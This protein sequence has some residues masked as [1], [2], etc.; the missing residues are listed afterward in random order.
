MLQ[1][2]ASL[3]AE[4][5]QVLQQF[6]ALDFDT[7]NRMIE[8][9]VSTH[10]LPLGIATNFIVNQKEIL[11]PMA[12]EEPSVVAA[13]SNAAKLCRSTGGFVT[14][15][16]APVMIGQIQLVKMENAT[17]AQENVILHK[18]ELMQLANA[19][20]A[21]LVKYGGGIRDIEARVLKTRMGE[22]LI[23]HLRVDVRDAMGAN[24]V[25][26]MAEKLTPRLQEI[27]EGQA[28]LRIVS[29][30][31][32]HRLARAKAVWRKEE[33]GVKTDSFSATGD[34]VVERILEAYAFAEADPFRATTHNKG[35]MNGID[36][37]AIA[38]GQDFRALE[39]GAHA[40]AWFQ[41][42]EYRPLSRY[43]KDRE[44]N[45]V[46]EI[47]L[48]IAVGLVGGAIKTHPTAKVSLKLLKI[49]SAQELAQVLAAVGLA[50]NFA[51]L[52]ALATEGIQRGHMTLHAKNIAVTAGAKG[53]QIDEIAA[54]LVAEKNV[55]V[56]R[57]G[58]LL[59]KRKKG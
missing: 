59:G 24:A 34:E 10:A 22:M 12:L 41:H 18:K 3:T 20:D 38:T 53:K 11:V 29:N 31:A 50:Q 35:I 51:A 33:L 26:T 19:A 28:R 8:N 56:S 39:A 6:G 40:F 4:D 52:R 48:P 9:V 27:S 30:L 49:N 36:A 14:D 23:V 57:A 47:E 54:Q 42:K 46:G 17:K 58:E 2:F 43:S 1:D 15:S 16:D 7:A 5:L 32:V 21:T 13:A 37:V 44:G 45:L 25:N 55:S